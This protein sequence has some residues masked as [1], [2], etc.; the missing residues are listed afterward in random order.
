MS[1]TQG[2][3]AQGAG[4]QD[5]AQ[6]LLEAERISI[7]AVLVEAGEDPMPLL[8]EAGIT[9]VLSLPAAL[10]ADSGT[11]SALSDGWGSSITA[12]W[13]PDQD[14]EADFSTDA[15][16]RD[17]APDASASHA[18]PATPARAVNLPAA[19]GMRPMAP[20]DRSG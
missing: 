7:K 5:P 12:T 4:T 14:E 8:R 20:I 10:N 9:E 15:D 19:F 3:P 17:V 1:D 11:A 18:D 16:P 6:R 2:N 13:E